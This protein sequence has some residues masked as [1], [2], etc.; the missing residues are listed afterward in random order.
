VAIEERMRNRLGNGPVSNFFKEL[1]SN[2]EYIVQAIEH[3]D[4]MLPL[5]GYSSARTEAEICTALGNHNLQGALQVLED[6][7]ADPR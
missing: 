1:A 4:N 5:G 2:Y 6:Q 7:R 3:E